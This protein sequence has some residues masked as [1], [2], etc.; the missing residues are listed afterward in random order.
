MDTGAAYTV[1]SV[2][3]TGL[4]SSKYIFSQ[5]SVYSSPRAGATDPV[6]MMAQRAEAAYR[7]WCRNRR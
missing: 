5:Q 6:E 7:D 1:K 4:D 2:H 3:E